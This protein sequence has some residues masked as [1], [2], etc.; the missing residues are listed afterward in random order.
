[1][2]GIVSAAPE[3]RGAGSRW[4]RRPAAL[5]N[6]RWCPEGTWPGGH[7]RTKLGGSVVLCLGPPLPPGGVT[8]TEVR[9]RRVTVA[10][11]TRSRGLAGSLAVG[12]EERRRARLGP[13]ESVRP[14]EPR[15]PG[16]LASQVESEP[17]WALGGGGGLEADAPAGKPP[18]VDAT[19]VCEAALAGWACSADCAGSRPLVRTPLRGGVS[20]RR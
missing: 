2:E 7:G 8:D 1:M 11:K 3:R 16:A 15:S 9:P 12:S 5:R 19:R 4:S 10:G 6:G 20:W 13:P 18:Q 17:P 14:H